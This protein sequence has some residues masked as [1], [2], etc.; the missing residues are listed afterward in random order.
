[1]KK[2]IQDY[3][4]SLENCNISKDRIELIKAILSDFVDYCKN[5]NEQ[6]PQEKAD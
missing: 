3:I 6:N 1:M 4:K 5:I 2:I